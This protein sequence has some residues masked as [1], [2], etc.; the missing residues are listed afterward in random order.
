MG[1]KQQREMKKNWLNKEAEL[2]LK[3]EKEQSFSEEKSGIDKQNGYE[4]FFEK[5]TSK[6][7]VLC[8]HFPTCAELQNY[9]F[10]HSFLA[11]HPIQDYGNFSIKELA[12]I[13]KVLYS[14]Q[15]QRE[16]QV[17]TFGYLEKGQ[18]CLKEGVFDQLKSHLCLFIGNEK[19]LDRY[20]KYQNSFLEVIPSF[21]LKELTNPDLVVLS[22]LEGTIRHTLDIRCSAQNGNCFDLGIE[23]YNYLKGCYEVAKYLDNISIFDRYFYQKIRNYRGIQDTLS[24]FVHQNDKFIAEVLISMAIFK[25]NLGKR[26]LS[27][28]DYRYIF[29]QMFSEATVNID[30]EVRREIPKVLK[31][32]PRDRDY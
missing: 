11:D 4:A 3:K 8:D 30:K 10:E 29:K 17:L 21:D 20:R 24:F 15:R 7:F 6:S 28:E 9:Y 12:E 22:A 23:Y 5:Q 13:I 32:I 16:Y 19:T 26:E 2:L 31:Y 27:N 18:I 25:K 14:L 1:K